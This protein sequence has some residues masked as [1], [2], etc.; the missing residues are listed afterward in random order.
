MTEDRA[1][2][3]LA[4]LL[5]LVV[6]ILY[7][8][9]RTHPKFDLSDLLTG[10]NGKV[11]LAK[12]GQTSALLVSTWGFVVLVQQGKLTETYFIGYMSV[13]TGYRLAQDAI[14]KK[15]EVKNDAA[16]PDT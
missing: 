1:S 7:R 5:L 16:K 10:D 8:W 4:A 3:L 2:L 15:S 13:W 14:T 11:S 12:F 6:F 9:Q